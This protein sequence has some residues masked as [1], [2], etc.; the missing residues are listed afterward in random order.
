M[1]TSIGNLNVKLTA[2]IG[3]FARG[4]GQG[5]R[6]VD[7]LQTKVGGLTQKIGR[8][9]TVGGALLGAGGLVAGLGTGVTLA[10]QYD[11]A[12]VAMATMIGS[13]SKAEKVFS[14]LNDFAASTPFEMPGL[15]DAT[16][17]LLA[18]GSTPDAVISELRMIGDIAAGVGQ[19]IDQLAELYGKARVSGRLFA[20]DINQLTGRGIP[21]IGALAK[22]FG[23]ADSEVKSLVQSGRVNF[24]HLQQA[25]R[26]L[27]AEGSQFGG[28]MAAQSQTLAGRW[29]TL[30]DNVGL[31]LRDFARTGIEIF[32]VTG[33][34]EGLTVAIS[35]G[36]PPMIAWVN[37][38]GDAVQ[39]LLVLV[40][41]IYATKK[42]IDLFNVSLATTRTLA[43]GGAI[44]AGLGRIAMAI[45]YFGGVIPAAVAGLKALAVS[46]LALKAAVF[47]AVA[48]FGT[49]TA[50]FIKS[51]IEGKRYS[52]TVWEMGRSL[53]IFD[54]EAARL[55]DAYGEVSHA[56]SGVAAAERAIAAAAN[57]T[58]RLAAAEEM[59]SALDQQIKARKAMLQLEGQ[60]SDDAIT[61][62]LTQRLEQARRSVERMQAAAQS[63]SLAQLSV[64]LDAAGDSAKDA[65]RQFDSFARSVYEST[66]NPAEAFLD[67]F[68]QHDAALRA[69]AFDSIDTATRGLFQSLDDAID[70]ASLDELR[71]LQHE[72]HGLA[73]GGHVDHDLYS[74]LFSKVA[75]AIDQ[76]TKAMKQLEAAGRAVYDAT[77]TPLEQYESKVGEL[78]DLLKAGVIDWDTYGRAIRQA[79]QELEQTAEAASDTRAQAL[80]ID[81][82][83]A[84]LARFE[85]ELQTIISI[86][87]VPPLDV[88]F[89]AAP[90]PPTTAPSS[91][92]PAPAPTTTAGGTPPLSDGLRQLRDDMAEKQLA[93]AQEQTRTLDRIERNTRT[94]TTTA[95]AWEGVSR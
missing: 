60:G 10:A 37:A 91:Y 73:R 63:A 85:R 13:A 50:A 81:S 57:D 70:N 49:I 94:A 2:G 90:T 47:A 14:D 71:Q 3:G 69:G 88:A 18:F 21:I 30:R 22:Q 89:A 9:A 19:P 23:V 51:R 92:G 17:K 76:P 27:T 52:D 74:K 40:P 87:E 95:T 66:R 31:A 16:K 64:E 38:H 75:E 77:R 62:K 39:T 42:A 45:S 12:G 32:N 80:R 35:T 58:A 56:A 65:Q 43:V 59:V 44:Y 55:Q 78:G 5:G 79:R 36:V 7:T 25:L 54:S 29:S 86:P 4:M 26:D 82:A 34:I 20:E 15:T 72:L 53:G 68:A 1:S 83:D 8:L 46:T 33:A 24:G 93:Q 61:N 41:S 6:Y 28:M 67:D 84:Q 11:Q 48:V